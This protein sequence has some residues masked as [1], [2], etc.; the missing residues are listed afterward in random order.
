MF[1]YD[2]CSFYVSLVIMSI[3]TTANLCSAQVVVELVN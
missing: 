1:V 2:Y 3:I